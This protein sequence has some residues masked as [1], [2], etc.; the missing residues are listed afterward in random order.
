MEQAHPP[1]AHTTSGVVSCDPP[2]DDK[3][4]KD[5]QCYFQAKVEQMCL[6]VPTSLHLAVAV[7]VAR[8]RSG[9]E[10]T[11]PWAHQEEQALPTTC[12]CYTEP[13]AG[14]LM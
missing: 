3:E 8:S 4:C 11:G 14:E 2:L 12:E 10:Q 9:L 7:A 6:L 5:T 1:E 13:V